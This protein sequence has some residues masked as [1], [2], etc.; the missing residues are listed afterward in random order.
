MAPNTSTIVRQIYTQ[1]QLVA[2]AVMVL[3]TWRTVS[4]RHEP[5]KPIRV[6][7]NGAGSV[8]SAP[9]SPDPGILQVWEYDQVIPAAG[10]LVSL[11][12]QLTKL[13]TG[14]LRKRTSAAS[15]PA[16]IAYVLADIF[17]TYLGY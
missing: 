8:A 3:Q 13:I 9:C 16:W 2:A 17:S 12:F 6:L 15:A 11:F 1:S 10:L 14:W 7:A 4:A 5:Q